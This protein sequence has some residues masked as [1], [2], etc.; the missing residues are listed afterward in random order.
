MRGFLYYPYPTSPYIG[1]G[2]RR[3]YI[4]IKK[5]RFVI[6][7]NVLL[8]INLKKHMSKKNLIIV[9]VVVLVALILGVFGLSNEA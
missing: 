4:C 8:I 9:V 6:L 5:Y 7:Q 2:E 1:G 3:G